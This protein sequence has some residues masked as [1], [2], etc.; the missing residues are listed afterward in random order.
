MQLKKSTIEVITESPEINDIVIAMSRALL[1]L[2]EDIAAE[3]ITPD[4]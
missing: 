1:M 3:L 2:S 4:I